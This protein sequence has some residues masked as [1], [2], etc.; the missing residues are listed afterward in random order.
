MIRPA[1]FI[2]KSQK[3]QTIFISWVLFQQI[4]EVSV[5]VIFSQLKLDTTE[6]LLTLKKAKDGKYKFNSI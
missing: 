1:H 4:L 5:C 6:I 2:Q 3:M